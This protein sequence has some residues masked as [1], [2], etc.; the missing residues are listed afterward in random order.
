M[1]ALD[2]L[3]RLQAGVCPDEAH[4]T[5]RAE[6]LA[7]DGRLRETVRVNGDDIAGFEVRFAFLVGHVAFDPKQH[8]ICNRG[9]YVIIAR[10]V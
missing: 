1:D 7:F 2:D 6:T 10:F 3:L 4:D 5:M 8:S 9:E